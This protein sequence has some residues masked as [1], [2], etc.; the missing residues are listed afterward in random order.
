MPL[1]QELSARRVAVELAALRI[2]LSPAEQ[3]LAADA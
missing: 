2:N 3:G 1:E